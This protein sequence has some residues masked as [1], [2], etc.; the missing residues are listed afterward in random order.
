MKQLPVTALIFTLCIASACSTGK[1]QSR[2]L[3]QLDWLIGFWERAN[4]KPGRSAH[5]RWQKIS[6]T[7]L[8]GW[9]VSL[10]ESDTTFVE[11]LQV[12]LKDGA[13]YYQADVSENPAP[14]PFAF[15]SI[16]KTGFV[17][18]NPNHDFPKK[19]QYELKGDTLIAT[20]SGNGKELIFR[21][22][23]RQ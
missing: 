9:G 7:T 10:H 20:T 11:K 6:D 4:T 3:D 16:S 15:T 8:I 22:K 14:V 5:E 19:I 2:Q 23:K 12:Y 18:E 1:A 21:F 17:C 13:L